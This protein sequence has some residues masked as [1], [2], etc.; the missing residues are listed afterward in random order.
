LATNR[1]E[2]EKLAEIEKGAFARRPSPTSSRPG[3]RT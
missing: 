3:I 1:G 2:I